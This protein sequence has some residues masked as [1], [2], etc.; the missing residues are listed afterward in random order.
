MAKTISAK[1]AKFHFEPLEKGG[2]YNVP[3]HIEHGRT[4]YAKNEE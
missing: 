3:I 2:I 1:H 4:S